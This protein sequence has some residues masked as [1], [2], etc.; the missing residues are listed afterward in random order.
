MKTKNI[1]CIVCPMGCLLTVSIDDRG[2]ITI[3][4]NKCPRGY[5]YGLKEVTN[6]ER[7][8]FTVVKVKKGILPVVSV[9]STKPIPKDYIP[10]LMKFL[11]SIEIEAPIDIHSVIVKNP[12]GLDLD[13]VATRRVERIR[14]TE[15]S[16]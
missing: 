14:N 12:L 11:S 5:E 10:K 3:K 13:I 4:G 9:K 2:N 7:P 8:F 16:R 15:E 1:I 6:P